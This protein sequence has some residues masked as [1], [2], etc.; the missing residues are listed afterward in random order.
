MIKDKEVNEIID[1]ISEV[2]LNYIAKIREEKELLLEEEM[3]RINKICI[4][5][6]I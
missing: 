2:I 3:P 6:S 4:Q 5:K 1:I